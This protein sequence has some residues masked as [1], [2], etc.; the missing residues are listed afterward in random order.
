MKQ[1]YYWPIYGE[2]DE[3]AFIWSES[4]GMMHAKE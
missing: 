2:E 4:R 1:T 3:V